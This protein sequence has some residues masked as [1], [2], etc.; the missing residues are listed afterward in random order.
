MTSEVTGT[1]GL[2][3]LPYLYR[4]SSILSKQKQQMYIGGVQEDTVSVP[5]IGG[6]KKL[7]PGYVCVPTM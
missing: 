3:L 2:Q 5:F 4:H 1:D 6:H 7:G